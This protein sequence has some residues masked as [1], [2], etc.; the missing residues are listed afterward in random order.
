MD[1]ELIVVLI[2]CGGIIFV[3]LAGMV[4]ATISYCFRQK[5][6]KGEEDGKV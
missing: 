6:G 1:R 5:Y 3:I 2:T 4:T